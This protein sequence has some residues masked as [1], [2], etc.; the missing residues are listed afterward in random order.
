MDNLA[1]RYRCYYFLVEPLGVIALTELER[2]A[3]AHLL[4]YGALL[5]SG[6]ALPA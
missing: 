1:T 4:G 5:R 2:A 3:R 6:Y